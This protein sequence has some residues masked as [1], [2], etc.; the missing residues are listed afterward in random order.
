MKHNLSTNLHQPGQIQSLCFEWF[1]SVLASVPL[2]GYVFYHPYTTESPFQDETSQHPTS[3]EQ[4]KCKWFNDSIA[5]IIFL[6]D[7]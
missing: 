7:L 1:H 2:I 5:L 3:L 6:L 4:E